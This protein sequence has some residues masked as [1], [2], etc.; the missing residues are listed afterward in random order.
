MNPWFSLQTQ[1]RERRWRLILGKA[2]EQEQQGQQ[3]QGNT[4]GESQEG[5]SQEQESPS[6]DSMLSEQDQALD[7]TLDGLYGEGDLGGSNDSSPDVARWLGDIRKYFPDSVA[8][9]LQQDALKKLKLQK[10]LESPEALAQIEPD[11]ELVTKLISLSKLIPTQT[12]E[13]A[14]QVVRQVVE[15]LQKKLEYPLLQAL[16]GALNRSVRKP[17]AFTLSKPTSSTINLNIKPL[18]QKP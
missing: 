15:E 18:C 14:R 7:E 5:Q 6:D 9:L 1:E 4:E 12:R 10:L 11:L 16:S 17:T 13:T 2:Q 3:G 8:Q